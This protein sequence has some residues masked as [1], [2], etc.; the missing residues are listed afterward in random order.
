MAEFC[1][2]DFSKDV[3]VLDVSSKAAAAYGVIST[4]VYTT[5]V[6]RDAVSPFYIIS[7]V[8]K[9]FY[10]YG[11]YRIYFHFVLLQ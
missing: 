2:L 10:R 9:S 11:Q 3:V 4:V 5:F 1:G 6:I 8:F 7:C